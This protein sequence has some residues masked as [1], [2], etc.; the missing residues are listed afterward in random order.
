M[1]RRCT[2]PVGL[3][4]TYHYF[5]R[6]DKD[7]SALKASREPAEKMRFCGGRRQNPV[8]EAIAKFPLPALCNPG[9]ST[10]LALPGGPLARWK[11]VV[12]DVQRWIARACEG[13]SCRIVAGLPLR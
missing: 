10:P 9:G 2:P 6:D 1:F 11:I 5:S 7:C 4:P 12:Q 3:V 13:F 8:L